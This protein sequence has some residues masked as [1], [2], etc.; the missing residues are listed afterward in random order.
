MVNRTVRARIAVAGTHEK[1]EPLGLTW[2]K[3]ESEPIIGRRLDNEKLANA[4]DK[5]S[6]SPRHNWMNSG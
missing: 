2:K 3:V 1:Q 4:L 6:I 5:T